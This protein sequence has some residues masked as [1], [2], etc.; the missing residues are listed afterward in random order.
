M[1]LLGEV[2]V[3]QATDASLAV[4]ARM[5][6]LRDAEPLLIESGDWLT[7]NADRIPQRVRAERLRQ[8]LERVVKLY[9]L[10]H[11]AE[12]DAGHDARAAEWRAEL[13]NLPGP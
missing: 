4:E 2:L 11:A 7:R 9:E 3:E 6:K 13:E 12:P 8:A 10:W 1:S 5:E